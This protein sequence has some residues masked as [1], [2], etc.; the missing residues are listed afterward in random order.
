MSFLHMPGMSGI[1]KQFSK[2]DQFMS[3]RVTGAES[4][5]MDDDFAKLESHT[6]VFVE[7]EADLQNKVREFL[8]PNPNVRAKM[9]AD[10][11]ISKLGVGIHT[12][13]VGL[14]PLPEKALGDAMDKGGKKMISLSGDRSCPYGE[15]LALSG[16]SL[17]Q[18]AELRSG[19]EDNVVQNYLEPLRDSQNRDLKEVLHQRKKLHG[20]KLDFDCKKRHGA[21]GKEIQDAEAKFAESY[22]SAQVAMNTILSNDAEYIIQLAAL[23]SSLSDYHSG[24]VQVLDQLVKDLNDKKEDALNKDRDDFVPKTLE[25]LT[26]AASSYSTPTPRKLNINNTNGN[27]RGG[28]SRG[29]SPA[30]SPWGSPAST[31][32][33]G[34]SNASTPAPPSRGSSRSGTPVQHS[35]PSA[36]ALYDFT[37]EAQG[38]LGFKEGDVIRLRRNIDDNW[39]DG[40]LRGKTGMFPSAYV[41]VVTPLP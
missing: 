29:A 32:G 27:N 36:R 16:E 38:E 37:A 6:D 33:H 10:S 25:S 13:K 14:M 12:S 23:S 35:F 11:G 30:A 31:P 3:E 20:R 4:T 39:M 15:A 40:E 7:M 2:A 1:K 34:P 17:N 18:L 8:Y 41:E 9:I 21:E 22:Q 24:C 19:M 26:G 28:S 5:K